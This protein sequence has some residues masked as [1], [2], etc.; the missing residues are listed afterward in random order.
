MKREQRTSLYS[1]SSR[2]VTPS[3]HNLES[4]RVS[5]YGNVK[6][7]VCMGVESDFVEAAVSKAVRFQECPLR[8]L[9]DRNNH[10][11]YSLFLKNATR[12]FLQSVN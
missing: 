4:V 9:P 11:H 12:E 1:G 6:L 10:N 2:R 3:G 7:R 8:E 5:A